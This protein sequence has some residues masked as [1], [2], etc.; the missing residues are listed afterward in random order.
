MTFDLKFCDR[1]TWFP[2]LYHKNVVSPFRV[3]YVR[4]NQNLD[5]LAPLAPGV[6]AL[7]GCNTVC[8]MP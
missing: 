2:Q 7:N 5:R 4:K 3:A 1:L 8:Y 6:F